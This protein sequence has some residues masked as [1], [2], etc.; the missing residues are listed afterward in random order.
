MIDK[1]RGSAEC[2]LAVYVPLLHRQLRRFVTPLPSNIDFE[3]EITT[4]K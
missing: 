1:L 3:Y 2:H 4:D